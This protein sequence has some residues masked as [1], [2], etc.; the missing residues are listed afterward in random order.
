MIE[1]GSTCPRGRR[2]VAVT[3]VSAVVALWIFATV[4]SGLDALTGVGAVAFA[5]VGA[6]L[7]V[8]RPDNRLG[9]V[10]LAIAST[11]AVLGS[12]GVY[13][14]HA[15]AHG[16]PGG[17]FV[18]WL[19][20]F[21]ATPMIAI[22]AGVLPQLFPTG[23]TLGPRWR[24]PL[25][26]AFGFMVFA[27]IGNGFYPQHL[28]SVPALENPY[29]IPAARQVF[30]L[31]IAVAAVCGAVAVVGTL[32]ALTVRWRRAS[33]DERQQLKW[34]AAAVCLLPI[35]LAMHD[36]PNQVSDSI[37]SVL[38][39]VIPV[40][41]GIAIL[42]YRLYDLDL[43]ISRTVGYLAVS[44]LVAG[45]YLAIVGVVEAAMSE[46]ASTAVHVI[47][48][49][50]AA[51]AFHPVRVRVQRA[52]DRLFY[53]ER[54]RPYEA[55]ARLAG[56]MEAALDPDDVLPTIVQTV[57]EALRLPYVAIEL[58]EA[59]GW[60]TAA[61]H[62]HPQGAADAFPMTYQGETVGRMAVCPR[63]AGESLDATD[64][65]LLTDLARQA[66]VAAQ[67][68]RATSALLR[69]RAE[70]VTAREEERRRL[71]RDLHD[72]LG[73][74]LAG[75]TMGLH[76]ARTFIDRDPA[77]AKRLLAGLEGQVEDAIA[78]IRRLV[79][80]LRPPA[81][82][83]FGLVRALQLHATRIEAWPDGIEIVIDSP[84][85]GL[86]RLPAAV[87]VAAYRIVTEAV[88]NVTRHAHARTCTVRLCL[89]GALELDVIDNG[90]GLDP[91]QP[92]GV[93][94]TAMRE[95]AAELGGALTIEQ[96]CPGTRV[97]ARLPVPSP[98]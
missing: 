16:W 57:A 66:G 92:A 42:R 80:G 65:R 90:R 52:V 63:R 41:I 44:A 17:T 10:F 4:L 56:R 84:P 19:A 61:E 91:A 95:R 87:E 59:G 21:M 74:T 43:V 40:T 72:G 54:A 3:W 22:V 53:G 25:F 33:R 51:A 89:N 77:E 8:R 93:G 76:A 28:E 26:G 85:E 46:S 79:Y 23:R 24:W 96:L 81:L 49:V 29:A 75:V 18:A 83:E 68:V 27:P 98:S 97:R 30:S 94:L 70:L 73:P 39:V 36:G 14:Q 78:D 20:D 31:M 34:F 6:V 45:L 58:R 62:G 60:H 37:L 55:V 1:V 13:A 2:V 64:Q 9:W 82:D 38:F 15:L 7:I 47:A 69:S 5:A 50:A 48:A 12:G 71:R 35:P 32:A 67:A 86:G 88:T 11:S